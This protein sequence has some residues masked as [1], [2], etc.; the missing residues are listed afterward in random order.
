MK[1]KWVVSTLGIFGLF[2]LICFGTLKYLHET[3][4]SLRVPTQNDESYFDPIFITK[5]TAGQ[6]PCLP[7]QIGDKVISSHMD[8]GFK[9]Y[10]SLE[11]SVL[12][13]IE[14][15]AFMGTQIMYGFRGYQ[16]R[17]NVF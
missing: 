7:I 15:K 16:Y 1:K 14:E 8:L 6:C 17:L 12:N 2:I 3:P 11:S 5:W 4:F 13:Q 10:F 9:G